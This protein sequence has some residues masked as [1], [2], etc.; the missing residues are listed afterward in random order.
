MKPAPLGGAA[1]LFDFELVVLPFPEL[2]V[3][4]SPWPARL[5]NN[6]VE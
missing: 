3:L 5:H 1:A 2:A 6:S 4:F